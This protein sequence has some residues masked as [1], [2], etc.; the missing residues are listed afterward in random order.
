[1]G[2][3][4]VPEAGVAATGSRAAGRAD[5]D[6]GETAEATAARRFSPGG[7]SFRCAVRKTARVPRRTRE[8]MSPASAKRL[9]DA[10]DRQAM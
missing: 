7:R 1:V 6:C 8:R 4:Q 9:S 5:P 10:A 3:G 2:S